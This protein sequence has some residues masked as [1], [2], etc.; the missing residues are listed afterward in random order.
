MSKKIHALAPM[1]DALNI[2]QSVTFDE[3]QTLFA[4]VLKASGD[5]P[6]AW[7]FALNDAGMNV[8]KHFEGEDG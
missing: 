8:G 4:E 7:L 5:T 6:P 2:K 3:A 1:L